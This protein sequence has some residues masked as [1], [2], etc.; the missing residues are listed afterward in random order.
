MFVVHSARSCI[1]SRVPSTT[2]IHEGSGGFRFKVNFKNVF[3]G[4]RRKS[5]PTARFCNPRTLIC[6]QDGLK[7]VDPAV[8]PRDP[9]YFLRLSGK[10]PRNDAGRVHRGSNFRRY[11]ASPL[12]LFRGAG[13]LFPNISI[14]PRVR[15][16]EKKEEKKRSSI[17]ADHPR[18]IVDIF[19]LRLSSPSR[20]M[21]SRVA[22]DLHIY[23]VAY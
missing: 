12:P 3:V 5:L 10:N 17:I 21:F 1:F 7:S 16:K 18:F 13:R 20:E 14:P 23:I 15:P 19:A 6:W 2:R 9:L 4:P 8:P 22:R 11:S